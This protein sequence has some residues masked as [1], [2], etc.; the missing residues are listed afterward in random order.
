MTTRAGNTVPEEGRARRALLGGGAVLALL[1]LIKLLVHLLSAENYGYF[2][3][4][5]YYIA[6]SERLDLGYVDFPPFVALVTAFVRATLG[7]SLLALHLLP[8]LAQGVPVAM[9]DCVIGGVCIGTS[10]HDTI[11]GSYQYDEIYALAG[12]DSI[13][14]GNDLEQ[15]YVSCGPGFDTVNQE[16]S[17]LVGAEKVLP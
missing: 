14:T 6:A 8:A 11:T 13:D 16:P 9:V 10:G 15:D 12:D 4:E 5:L 7:D 3:D 17:T 1:V 2:R